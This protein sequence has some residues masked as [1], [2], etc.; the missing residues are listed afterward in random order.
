MLLLLL[1]FLF[2]KTIAFEHSSSKHVNM[3][4]DHHNR[5]LSS[6]RRIVQ[7]IQSQTKL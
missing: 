7:L 1:L 4:N 5:A 6:Y 3:F 2:N